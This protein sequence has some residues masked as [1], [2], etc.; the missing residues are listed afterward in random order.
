M[1][2]FPAFSFTNHSTLR[3]VGSPGFFTR[4]MWVAT[5]SWGVTGVQG[6]LFAAWVHGFGACVGGVG[7]PLFVG[8]SAA[9]AKSAELS[10]VS[11]IRVRL[12]VVPLPAARLVGVPDVGPPTNAGRVFVLPV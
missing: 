9:S 6:Q 1:L 3:D 11:V 5:V 7:G 2:G 12:I 10:L 4:K 8:V